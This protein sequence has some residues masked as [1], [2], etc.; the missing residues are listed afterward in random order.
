M[1]RTRERDVKDG[2]KGAGSDSTRMW[3]GAGDAR[4]EVVEVMAV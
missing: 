3:M 4:W 1:I 2:Q